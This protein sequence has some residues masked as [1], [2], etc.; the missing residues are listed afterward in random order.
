MEGRSKKMEHEIASQ[1]AKPFFTFSDAINVQQ[2]R[3]SLS[4]HTHTNIHYAIDTLIILET[5]TQSRTENRQKVLR[6]FPFIEFHPR[7]RQGRSI[8]SAI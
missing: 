2:T 6:N 5:T 7:H 1:H 8:N 3:H 4:T